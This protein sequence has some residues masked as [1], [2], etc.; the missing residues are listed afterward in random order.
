MVDGKYSA[1]STDLKTTYKL[2]RMQPREDLQ[3][4]LSVLKENAFSLCRG[5]S[6]EPWAEAMAGTTR[7]VSFLDSCPSL[8]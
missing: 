1:L 5:R 8:L 3:D 2:R 6:S 7:G 4:I